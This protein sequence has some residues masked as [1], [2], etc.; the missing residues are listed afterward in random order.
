MGLLTTDI[1][2]EIPTTVWTSS[3]APNIPLIAEQ[4]KRLE[5]EARAQLRADGVGDE[6]ITLERSADCRYMGQGYELRVHAPDG[7]IDED[8]VAATAA[9]F[10]DV[11]GRTYSQRFEDKPVHLVNI[12]V[13]GVGAVPH[14]VIGQIEASGE[15][16]AEAL[17]TTARALFWRDEASEPEWVET[18]VYERSRLKAG[19]RISGPA[20]I[21]QFD[22]TTVI[23]MNQQATVDT[24]GHLILERT[25]A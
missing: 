8:W 9:A 12:R 6:D 14:V 5:E 2:Y 17:K 16:P 19:N 11:H 23:G 3:A 10:H 24:V 20:I 21:E 13:T 25:N 18:P 22:S 15:D 4:M 1:R 7:Q